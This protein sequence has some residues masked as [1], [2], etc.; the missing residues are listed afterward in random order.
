MFPAVVRARRRNI[1]ATEN[2]KLGSQCRS[3]SDATLPH[4]SSSPKNASSAE[5]SP[6][7]VAVA[8]NSMLRRETQSLEKSETVTQGCAGRTQPATSG[9][10]YPSQ[11]R[12]R[13]GHSCFNATSHTND[14][15]VALAC[16]I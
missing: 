9:T 11:H 6:E 1:R 10:M 4:S 5:Q 16:V 2:L 15:A 8:S 12:N 14:H 13:Q 7:A 3:P